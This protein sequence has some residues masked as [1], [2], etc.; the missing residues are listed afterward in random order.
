MDQFLK[1]L[2]SPA[3]LTS[4]FTV[5]DVALT[6]VLSFVLSLA[7]AWV[8]RYTHKGVSYSQSF[9]HT[10]VIMGTVVGLIMLIIGSNIARAFAL[11]GALSII[12]FRNAVKE[13]RDVAFVFLAMAIGMAC[14][15]KFYL[16]A[17]AATVAFSAFIIFIS[18]LNLFAKEFRERILRVYLGPDQDYETL[19]EPVFAA[20]TD[21]SA[22]VSIETV[23]EGELQEVVYTIQ[24]K[25]RANPQALLEEVRKVNG[26]RKVT[27]VMGQQEIDI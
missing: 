20:F 24:L 17:V 26:N 13:S 27:L 5:F 12:R 21:E 8:Y 3:D 23:R 10:L 7:V 15:T 16:L 1:E 11:V 22:L 14:G 6:L 19:L 25:R 18:R 9:A 4:V 2:T